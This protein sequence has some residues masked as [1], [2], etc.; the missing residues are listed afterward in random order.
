MVSIRYFIYIG[1]N[2]DNPTKDQR[3]EKSGLYIY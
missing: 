1:P 3:A 2:R